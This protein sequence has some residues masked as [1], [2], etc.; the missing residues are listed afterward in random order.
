MP[1]SSLGIVTSKQA[2]KTFNVS[3]YMIHADTWEH[4]H[5]V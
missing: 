4:E 3:T 5:A 1:L 2:V